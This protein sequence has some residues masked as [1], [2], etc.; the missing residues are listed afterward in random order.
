MKTLLK[1]KVVKKTAYHK[2][3]YN[4]STYLSKVCFTLSLEYFTMKK[5]P[6][7]L[8]KGATNYN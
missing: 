4:Y 8:T 6:K 3:Y 5:T 7:E 1:K 2:I